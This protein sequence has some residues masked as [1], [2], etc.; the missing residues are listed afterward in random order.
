MRFRS[1]DGPT[2]SSIFECIG[3]PGILDQIFVAAPRNAR[4]VVVGVCLELD[5][6][7]PLI[8]IN[9][10]LLV[11]YVLGYTL[12]EFAQTLQSDR[13]RIIRR[14]ATHHRARRARRSCRVFRRAAR[15]ATARKNSRR[16]VAVSTATSH[17]AGG[18]CS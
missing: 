11:Q 9:K 18:Y 5:H 4:I 7:R 15:S 10:E 17:S 8:A 6:S 14:G 13:R 12:A 16:A 3:V 2:T 1:C